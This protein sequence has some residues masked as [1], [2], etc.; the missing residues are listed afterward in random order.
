MVLQDFHGLDR[1][2]RKM[3][4]GQVIIAFQD[5][6]SLHIETVDAL[7]VIL[8]VSRLRDFHARQ[9]FQDVG[10]HR[11]LLV[12]QRGDRIPDRITDFLDLVRSHTGRPDLER[13]RF[14]SHLILTLKRTEERLFPVTQQGDGQGVRFLRRC[15]LRHA[16]LVRQAIT[17]G[18]P[19]FFDGTDNRSRNRLTGFR[20]LDLETD[21]LGGQGKRYSPK[22]TDGECPE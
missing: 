8:H 12:L 11:I 3:L 17:D 21:R 6:L 15:H 1:I 20:I 16:T 19:S 10:K 2:D 14:Q 18:P 22:S 4:G 13:F 7:A 5:I 9:P